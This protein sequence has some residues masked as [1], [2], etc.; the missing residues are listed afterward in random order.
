M[1]ILVIGPISSGKGIA[2]EMLKRRG[3]KHHSFSFEIRA[4]AKERGITINRKSLDRL[5]SRL[6]KEAP[7]TSLLAEKIV[8]H[9]AQDRKK[10]KK[11]FVVEGARRL[12]DINVFRM[13]S[14]AS[15][16]KFVV[17]SVDAP[18]KLRFSR[19]LVR[20]RKGDPK[21]FADF[22]AMDKKETYGN[23]GQEVAKLM[24]R[25][26]YTIQNTGDEKTLRKKLDVLM[27]K[28]A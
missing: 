27:K 5:G 10:G 18:A 22:Q 19:L 3:Y 25:A 23:K 24:K 28:I 7:K 1:I 4:V 11:K 16:T 12:D 2:A 13:Y 14:K 6:R 26:D 15:K 21:T 9:M 20:G 8:E 17:L